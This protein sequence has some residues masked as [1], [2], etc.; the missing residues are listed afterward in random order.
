MYRST[1]V[2]GAALIA[3]VLTALTPLAAGARDDSYVYQS[4]PP[5][6][7]RDATTYVVI[8]TRTA[9]GCRFEY[10]ELTLRDGETTRVQRDVGIDQ[11]RCRKLVEEGVPTQDEEVPGADSSITE[12]IGHR[13]AK[14][15]SVAAAASTVSSGY[16]KTWFENSL[17][18]LLTGDTTYIT[19]IWNGTCATSGSAS[20]EWS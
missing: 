16:H 18:H 14:G 4:N 12:T 19:W 17:G 5:A 11:G 6:P 15:S 7:L 3:V 20:G 10:P 1:R 9:D 13:E 8:G 2:F